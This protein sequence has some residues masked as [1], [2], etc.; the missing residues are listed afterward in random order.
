MHYHTNRRLINASI[1]SFTS[2]LERVLVRAL[3]AGA[4]GTAVGA[5]QQG[6]ITS[7]LCPYRKATDETEEHILWHCTA[8]AQAWDT[9]IQQVHALAAKIPELPPFPAWPPCLKISGLAPDLPASPHQH[10]SGAA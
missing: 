10:A 8:W 1:A 7:P 4:L 9:H 2:E 6:L 5:Y 3:L